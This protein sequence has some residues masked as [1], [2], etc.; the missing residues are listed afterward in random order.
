MSRVIRYTVHI[1]VLYGDIDIEKLRAAIFEDI[2][3][4]CVDNAIESFTGRSVL[5]WRIESTGD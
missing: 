2:D 5:A 1:D 4:A 3:R